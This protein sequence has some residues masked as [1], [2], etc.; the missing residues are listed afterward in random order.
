MEFGQALRWCCWRGSRR[1]CRRRHLSCAQHHGAPC[2]ALLLLWGAVRWWAAMARLPSVR[3]IRV[4]AW[5]RPLCIRRFG[6][7]L[8]QHECSSN[9]CSSS[10]GD[11]QFGWRDGRVNQ[12]ASCQEDQ[13]VLMVVAP[14]LSN[15]DDELCSIPVET[16]PWSS[17]AVQRKCCARCVGVPLLLA[18]PGDSTKFAPWMHSG[19][20]ASDPVWIHCH[21]H[22]LI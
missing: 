6:V 19:Q 14:F 20:G 2:G 11:F 4:E 10:H 16:V 15:L 22:E 8:P 12:S 17:D 1:C 5:I 13:G 18:H 7:A 21:S 3:Q 9:A